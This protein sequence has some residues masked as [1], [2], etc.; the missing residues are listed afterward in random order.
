MDTWTDKKISNKKRPSGAVVQW[1]SLLHNFIQLSL[2]SGS[3]QVQ[4]LLSVSEIRD[5]EDLWQWSWL[6]IR[7]NAFHQSTIPQKQY[8]QVKVKKVSI[9]TCNR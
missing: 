4:T 9:Y 6:E 2:N 1:L 8:I 5:G 7:L 3:A